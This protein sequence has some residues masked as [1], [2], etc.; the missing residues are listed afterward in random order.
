MSTRTSEK[1]PFDD[2]C[3]FV[4]KLGTAAHGYGSNTARLEAFLSRVTKAL[5]F[6]GAFR[7]TPNDIWFAFQEHEDGWQRT[8][9]TTMPGTGLELA[10]LAKVGEL[11]DEVEA[12]QVSV[13][14]ATARLDDIEETPHPWGVLANAA[15]YLFAGVGFAM[16]MSGGWWD[17]LFSALY[18]LVVFGMVELAGHFGVRTA[19]WLPLSTAFVAGV[20]TAGTKLLVPEL[21]LVLVTLSAI[22]IL[23]PGYPISVGSRRAREQPRR[24]RHGEPHEWARVPRQ[25]VC[26]GLARRQARRARLVDSQRRSQCAGESRLALVGSATVDRG[27]VRSLSDGTA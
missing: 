13:S 10:R 11:V 19:V 21:N 12:G 20:L 24:F 27:A 16:L 17:V 25:A 6:R 18:S 26:R 8:H 7:S 22:L 2:A 15:G 14:Q 1:I 4:I 5:G 3:R 9:L 23:I